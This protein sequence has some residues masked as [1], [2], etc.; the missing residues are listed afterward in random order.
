MPIWEFEALLRTRFEH[1]RF[2]LSKDP[3]RPTSAIVTCAKCGWT[4]IFTASIIDTWNIS[5]KSALSNWLLRHVSCK[6]CFRP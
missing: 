4:C 6:G 1:V 3:E 5:D 2:A